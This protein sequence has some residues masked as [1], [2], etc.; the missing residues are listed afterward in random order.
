MN[1]IIIKGISKDFEPLS[2]AFIVDVIDEEISLEYEI[3][4]ILMINVTLENE[5]LNQF[6]VINKK[7][8]SILLKFIIRIDYIDISK[9]KKYKIHSFSNIYKI[10]SNKNTNNSTN[11]HSEVIDISTVD[12]NNI[13]NILYIS[14]LFACSLLN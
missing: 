10:C 8:C 6:E 5:Y 2:N 3:L 14:V 7:Y 13:K 1:N 11:I 4:K 12:I 9:H